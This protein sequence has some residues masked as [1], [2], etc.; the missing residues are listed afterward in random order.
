MN[1]SIITVSNIYLSEISKIKTEDVILYNIKDMEYFKYDENYAKVKFSLVDFLKVQACIATKFPNPKNN[2]IEMIDSFILHIIEEAE[3]CNIE[4]ENNNH[5][6]MIEEFIDC[7]MYVFSF[8]YTYLLKNCI[9]KND[10]EYEVIFDELY[11]EFIINKNE[12]EYHNTNNIVNIIVKDF[13]WRLRRLFPERKYHKNYKK[14]T[15]KEEINRATRVFFVF[16]DIIDELS[17]KLIR[18]C[19]MTLNDLNRKILEKQ[20]YILNEL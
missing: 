18:E 19:G 9:N 20:N 12:L 3:E 11:K 10:E 13:V 17:F 16:M 14:L 1:N 8:L 2:E 5:E 15:K 6:K 4:I 7:F